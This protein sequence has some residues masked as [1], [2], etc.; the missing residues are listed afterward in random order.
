MGVPF[1]PLRG[2]AGT[3]TFSYS[4]AARVI[5]PYTGQELTVVPALWPDVAIIH[6]HEAD[7]FGNCRIRGTSVTD[8]HLARAAKKLIVSCER[9]ISND[10]IRRDPTLTAIPFYCV[11]AVC[12]VPCGSYPG[13]MPYEYYSD[14]QHLREWLTVERD[15]EAYLAFVD[16]LIFRTTEFAE[17]LE[18][19]GGEARMPELRKQEM[20]PG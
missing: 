11:D 12:H 5:C 8:W 20:E 2:F 1:L 13:N 18:R 4:A 3:D 17:Y 19:C 14:E 7:P 9:L 6:V 10:E 15:R 16:R